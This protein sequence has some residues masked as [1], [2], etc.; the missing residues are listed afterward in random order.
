MHRDREL[1]TR[2]LRNVRD[3]VV[4]P[5]IDQTPDELVAYNASLLIKD[6]LHGDYIRENRIDSR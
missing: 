6:G 3:G 4:D 5:I 2:I 1:Q